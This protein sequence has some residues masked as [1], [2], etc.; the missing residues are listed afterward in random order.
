MAKY[1]V[2]RYFNDL[3]DNGYLYTEGDIFPRE[4]ISVSAAR[5]KELSGSKNLQNTPLIRAVKENYAPDEK[6]KRGRKPSAR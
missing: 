4:G 3:Q 2:I 1:E 5:I 6:P